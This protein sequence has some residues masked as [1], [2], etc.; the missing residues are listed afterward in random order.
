[1]RAEAGRAVSSAR[2]REAMDKMRVA[3]DRGE[4][5]PSALERRAI[6]T[7]CRARGIP[8]PFRPVMRRTR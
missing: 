3:I 7:V 4:C 5:R 1:M 8:S 6:T 2:L